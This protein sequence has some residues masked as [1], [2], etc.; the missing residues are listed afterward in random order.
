MGLSPN[1]A[2][3]ASPQIWEIWSRPTCGFSI[4]APVFRG[5]SCSLTSVCT[6]C[7]QLF[8]NP[9]RSHGLPCEKQPSFLS[10][11]E[12]NVTRQ[13]PAQGESAWHR[14]RPKEPGRSCSWLA[15]T[16]GGPGVAQNIFRPFPPLPSAWRF[17]F[18]CLRFPSAQAHTE[19]RK[20]CNSSHG[21]LDIL[22][23]NESVL[24]LMPGSETARLAV[25]TGGPF[26]LRREMDSASACYIPPSA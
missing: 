8:H 14:D 25:L 18:P 10:V 6:W 4:E 23:Q 22:F 5:Q 13:H 17:M 21:H 19:A 9:L 11:T 7:A 24:R 16:R 15:E 20:T 3:C 2:A 26:R 1:V 12:E